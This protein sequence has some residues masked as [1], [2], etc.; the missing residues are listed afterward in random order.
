MFGST[1]LFGR[2]PRN[3]ADKFTDF[4][5]EDAHASGKSGGQTDIYITPIKRLYVVYAIE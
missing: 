3:E 5:S 4:T 1:Y 2:C